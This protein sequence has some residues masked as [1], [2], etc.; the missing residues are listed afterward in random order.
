MPDLTFSDLERFVDSRIE[1]KNN[2]KHEHEEDPHVTMSK[3]MPR[4]VNFGRCA[5]GNCGIEVK[6]ARGMNTEFKTCP[7][8]RTNTVAKSQGF[9][10]TCGIEHKDWDESDVRIELAG[11]QQ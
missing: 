7:G 4:S 10:P 2:G 8:C 11:E 9:C 3:N 1:L 6:N 5:N